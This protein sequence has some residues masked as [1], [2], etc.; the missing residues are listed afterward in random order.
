MIKE[1]LHKLKLVYGKISEKKSP[2]NEKENVDDRT[3][4]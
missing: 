4:A 1:W 2:V 3:S